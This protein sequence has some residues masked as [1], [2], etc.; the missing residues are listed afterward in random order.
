MLKSTTSSSDTE[1][2]GYIRRGVR[3][4]RDPTPGNGLLNQW[5][6]LVGVI[7]LMIAGIGCSDRRTASPIE[8]EVMTDILV[9][10][11][12]ERAQSDV[13]V[14]DTL[15]STDAILA[16]HRVSDDEFRAAMAYYAEH[17]DVYVVLLDTVIDRMRAMRPQAD[18]QSTPSS[19]LRSFADSF[20]DTVD[21]LSE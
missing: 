4:Y 17:P 9:D 13:G 8:P 6:R 5:I 21:T 12:L 2:R 11:H 3:V 14:R 16:R 10:L 1:G 18:V 15:V 20:R 19:R 7:L